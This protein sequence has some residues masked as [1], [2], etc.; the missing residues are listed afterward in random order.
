MDTTQAGMGTASNLR[1]EMARQNRKKR[2]LAA[3][4]GISPAAVTRRISGETPLDVNELL[5]IAEW[6]D[7]PVT[8]LLPGR[9]SHPTTSGWSGRSRQDDLA[10][11]LVGAAA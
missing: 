7:V 3:L 2:E 9:G 10:E 4:L 8:E 6:L 1:A 11:L 5:A